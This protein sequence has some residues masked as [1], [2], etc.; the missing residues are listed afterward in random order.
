MNNGMFVCLHTCISM[1]EIYVCARV[2]VWV[3]MSRGRRMMSGVLLCHS[4][5][6]SFEAGSLTEPGARHVALMLQ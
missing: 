5:H 1:Y 2:C 4:A 3:H 6:C